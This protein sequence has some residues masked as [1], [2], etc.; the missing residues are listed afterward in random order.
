MKYRHT[1]VSVHD[2][3]PAMSLGLVPGGLH[4]MN[5]DGFTWVS[6]PDQWEPIPQEET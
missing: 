4:L 1:H 2:G 6:G 5:E 3:S